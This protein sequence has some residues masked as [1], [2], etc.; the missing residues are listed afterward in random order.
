M[1]TAL[2]KT[3]GYMVGAAPPYGGAGLAMDGFNIIG[4]T[5]L[6]LIGADL[7]EIGADDDEVGAD[8]D[9]IWADDDEVGAD[10]DPEVGAKKARRVMAKA[11]KMQEQARNVVKKYGVRDMQM[12]I[13]KEQAKA[14]QSHEATA[15]RV[16]FDAAQWDKLPHLPLPFVIANIPAKGTLAVPI[17]ASDP[18][19]PRKL[20]LGS[21]IAGAVDVLGVYVGRTNM[22]QNSNGIDGEDFADW[23]QPPLDS[24]EIEPSTQL[25]VAVLNKTNAIITVKGQLSCIAAKYVRAAGSRR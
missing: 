25:S 2:D 19:L 21:G 23:E 11:R 8:D 20:K 6:A 5:P 22:F 9:E 7:D 15:Q 10:G 14:V 3:F 4:A 13:A 17:N 12:Q 18:C 1:S 24:D 16:R